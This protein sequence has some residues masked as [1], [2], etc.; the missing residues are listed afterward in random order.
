MTLQGNGQ[1]LPY[2][3]RMSDHTRAVLKALHRQ[4]AVAGTGP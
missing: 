2:T 1:P 3:V 4:A